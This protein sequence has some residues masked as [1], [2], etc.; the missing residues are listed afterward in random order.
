MAKRF[1]LRIILGMNAQCTLIYD[2]PAGHKWKTLRALC[3]YDS[4][5]D[6]DNTSSSGTTMEFLFY[7]TKNSPYTFDL[8]KLTPVRDK[9]SS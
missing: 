9:N 1:V 2:L 7:V 8:T 6:T 5:C 4:S 3:G